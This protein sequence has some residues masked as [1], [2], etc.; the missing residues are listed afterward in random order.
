MILQDGDVL[1]IPK[2]LQTVRIRGQVL[3]PTRVSYDKS[4]NFKDYISLAGGFTDDA[5]IKKSYVVYA[6]GRAKRT[7]KFLFFKTF[8]N[9]EPGADI[10]IPER[11]PRRPLSAGEVLGIT[12]GLASLSFVIIQIV[13]SIN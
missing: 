9:V 12:S 10:F 1:S 6:N 13:N 5:R 7:K 4:S 2:Q 3:Y 8:P 11:P